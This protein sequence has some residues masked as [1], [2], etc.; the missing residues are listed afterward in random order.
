MLASRVLPVGWL[1]L[2]TGLLFFGR[3]VLV[4][5]WL[6]ECFLLLI[7]KAVVG[8]LLV[9]GLLVCHRLV[10]AGGPSLLTGCCIPL[11]AWVVVGESIASIDVVTRLNRLVGV[12][13]IWVG[14]VMIV[15]VGLVG[16]DVVWILRMSVRVGG[17]VCTVL[18]TVVS[19]V[20]H[21][22]LAGGGVA[23]AMSLSACRRWLGVHE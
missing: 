9:R 8:L 23:L 5:R 18:A 6:M 16:G 17:L 19:S 14:I 4:G 2:V 7:N 20:R 13:C 12:V 11:S 1:L 21:L 10:V 15:I 3:L 22:A